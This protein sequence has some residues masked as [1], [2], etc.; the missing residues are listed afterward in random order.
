MFWIPVPDMGAE[1][2][3]SLDMLAGLAMVAAAVG[4]NSAQGQ[5]PRVPA[6]EAARGSMIKITIWCQ[7]LIFR[8]PFQKYSTKRSL[9]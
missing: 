1:L 7:H 8:Q 4:Q 3:E 5:R 6:Q 2:E 9:F